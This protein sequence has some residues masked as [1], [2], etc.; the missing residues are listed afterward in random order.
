MM[1]NAIKTVEKRIKE[2]LVK[3]TIDFEKKKSTVREHCF[4]SQ[5]T[6]SRKKMK[7]KKPS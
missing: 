6:K 1:R 2:L 3:I 4:E 5:K 7:K